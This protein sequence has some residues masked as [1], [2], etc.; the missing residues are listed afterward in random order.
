[1]VRN[2]AFRTRVRVILLVMVAVV[3]SM[4]LHHGAMASAPTAHGHV[5]LHLDY[6]LEDAG[7]TVHCGTRPHS[8]PACCGIGLCLSELPVAPQSELLA[9]PRSA[10]CFLHRGLIPKS[11]L[12]RIDRPPKTFARVAV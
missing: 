9:Q 6:R 10:A 2:A 12:S 7:C 3:A 11:I 5:E 8:M 4:T 1:M